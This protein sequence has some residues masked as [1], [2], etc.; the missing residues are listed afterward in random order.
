MYQNANYSVV[1]ACVDKISFYA[2]HPG[3]QGSI[4]ELLVQNAIERY[5]YFLRGRGTGDV[6]VE[7]TNSPSDNEIKIMHRRCYNEGTEH[8]DANR[9]QYALSSADIKIKPKSKNIAGLQFADL[10]ASTCFSHCKRIHAG[11][12]P[13][14]RF[15][16][17]VADIIENDKFY[18]NP[19]NG[20]PRGYGRVWRP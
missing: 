4:Y 15:A 20:D 7:A 18:R 3:W 9:I 10:L 12:A 16:M 5:F 14:D 6:M 8:I 19:Q 1:C 11:G 17:R 2:Q 13:Y